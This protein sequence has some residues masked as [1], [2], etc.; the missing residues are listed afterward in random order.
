VLDYMFSED[1]KKMV[2]YGGDYLNYVPAKNLF[3]PID[4]KEVIADN[5]VQPSD[6]SKIVGRMEW[7][8]NKSTLLKNDI[9]TLEILRSNLW[10]RPI[11]F[12][13]SVAPD[14]YLG[15][16]NYFQQ[17]GLTYR[18]VPYVTKGPEDGLPGGIQ[19]EV[20]YD[21]MMNKFA[22]GG[23]DKFNVYLDENIGRMVTNLRSNF[24]RLSATLISEG[25]KDSAIKVLDRC[26]EV[27]PEKN[28]PLAINSIALGKNYYEAGAI[29]KGSKLLTRCYDVYADQLRYYTSLDPSKRKYFNEEISN[30]L[31]VMNTIGTI[32]RSHADSTLSQKAQD[33]FNKYLNY[34]TPPER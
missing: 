4:K 22:W 19:S 11:Y 17:E 13:I 8:L 7:R 2:E 12:A 14:A 3:I 5:V 23:V 15:L 25:K 32:A 20:M 31:Y 18:I 6:T 27:L 29:D 34:Y 1:R 10:K 16:N 26:E 33:S 21:N 9:L 28:V 24:A 30:G